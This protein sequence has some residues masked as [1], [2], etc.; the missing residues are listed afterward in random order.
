VGVKI[1]YKKLA[2]QKSYNIRYSWKIIKDLNLSASK[3]LSI[4]NMELSKNSNTKKICL[5]NSVGANLKCLRQLVMGALK[6]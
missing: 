4:I 6:L 3:C 5:T 2:E 1:K